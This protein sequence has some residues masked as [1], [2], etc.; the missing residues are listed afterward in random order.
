MGM[1]W[2][3]ENDKLVTGSFHDGQINIWSSKGKLLKKIN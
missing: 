1:S 3:K 2:N